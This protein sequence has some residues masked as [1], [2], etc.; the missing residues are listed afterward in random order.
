MINAGWFGETQIIKF[1]IDNGANI[2]CKNQIGLGL[3]ECSERAEKQ[4]ND[5]SLKENLNKYNMNY[6]LQFIRRN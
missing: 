1:L 3:L 2:D 4:F 5:N 6:K